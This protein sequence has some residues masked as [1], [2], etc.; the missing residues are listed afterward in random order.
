MDREADKAIVELNKRYHTALEQKKTGKFHNITRYLSNLKKGRIRQI[1]KD[2]K[3]RK[4][5]LRHFTSNANVSMEPTSEP[6][7]LSESRIAVYSCITGNYDGIIDPLYAEPGVDYYMFTDLNLPEGSKWKKIDVTQF[8]EYK[9]LTS[10]Q[11]NR[12][13]K[14]LPFEYLKGYDYS[15]Y[16]DGNI[17]IIAPMSPLI[18]E[19]GKALLGMHFHNFRDCIYDEIVAIEHYKKIDV[20]Q[21]RKQLQEYESEGFPHHFGLYENGVMI[22]KHSDESVVRLMNL[23]WE[24]YLRYSTRD[25]FSFPYLIWKSGFDRT[26]IHIIG[27]NLNANPR[28]NRQIMHN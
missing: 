27:N 13:I 12:R 19:M 18:E 24:E 5:A 17:E 9:T 14:M 26:R 4:Y 1:V 11:M 25:Q 2:L 21:A 16:V 10:A 8:S 7:D 28:F 23:W 20:E 6:L 3:Y 15:I 22:R